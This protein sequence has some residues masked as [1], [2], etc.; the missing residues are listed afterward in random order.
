MWS[1]RGGPPQGPRPRAR[2]HTARA[3]L[4]V[5]WTHWDTHFPLISF[6]KFGIGFFCL[7]LVFFQ[8]SSH[9]HDKSELQKSWVIS[10][11]SQ[12]VQWKA[13]RDQ[14]R[15]CGN[16]VHV[17]QCALRHVRPLFPPRVCEGYNFTP[18]PPS[19]T[20]HRR[21]SAVGDSILFRLRLQSF[22]QFTQHRI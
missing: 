7:A 4:A 8:R 6:G 10:S 15:N 5:C 11:L 19:H 9:W 2:K 16:G 1:F 21:G 18:P 22:V 17:F 13:E 20:Q 12:N 3:H 14:H